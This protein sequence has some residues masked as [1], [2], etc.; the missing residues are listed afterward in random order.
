MVAD[1]Y[2]WTHIV[3]VVDDSVHWCLNGAIPFKTVFGRSANYTFTWLR[4]SLHP[5]DAEIDDILQQIRARTRG[6]S[7]RTSKIS[8]AQVYKKYAV[9][10]LQFPL[11]RV[12]QKTDTQYYFWDNFGN[13][14][15]ILTLL[16]MLQAEIYGA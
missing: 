14:A 16:S 2:H 8:S 15:P 4:I 6:L 1:N 11:Y 12:V 7:I 3:L 13:S 10:L 9:S 5:T